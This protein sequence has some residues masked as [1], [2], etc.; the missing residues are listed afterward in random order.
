MRPLLAEGWIEARAGRGAKARTVLADLE[1]RA[2]R[3]YV[4]AYYVAA[5]HAELGDADRAFRSLQQGYD[6]RPAYS[7]Y[8]KVEPM[9]DGLRDDP[10]FGALLKRVGLG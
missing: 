2:Q 7:V 6:E 3:Q 5:I 10:R 9:C 4:S 8:L 1:E